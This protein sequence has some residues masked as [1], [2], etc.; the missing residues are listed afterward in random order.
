SRYDE[1]IA[2][3]LPSDLADCSEPAV[4][5][6]VRDI[7]YYLYRSGNYE[8]ARSFADRFVTRWSEVSGPDHPDV[9]IVRRHLGGIIRELG[10][11]QAAYDLD[12]ATLA[13]MTDVLG[14]EDR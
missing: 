5:S 7:V 1:L 9:L 10:E 3:I 4:R 8:S 11:Y 6:T 12:S 13:K 14:A 2:H